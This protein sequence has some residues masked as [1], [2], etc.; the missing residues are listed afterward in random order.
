[1]G[2]VFF[3]WKGESPP[4]RH[5]GEY[6]WPPLQLQQQNAGSSPPWRRSRGPKLA[7][8]QWQCQQVSIAKRP[9]CTTQQGLELVVLCCTEVLVVYLKRFVAFNAETLDSQTKSMSF[10]AK[11][12]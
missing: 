7:I 2:N 8:H 4:N 5:V 12:N 10:A 3:G 11:P 1:M 6:F 9:I